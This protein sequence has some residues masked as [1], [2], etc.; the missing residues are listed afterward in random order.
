MVGDRDICRGADM[1]CSWG[2]RRLPVGETK[3][4]EF[5]KII[6]VMLFLMAGVIVGFAYICSWTG[7]C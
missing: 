4:M 2:G 6:A 5:I 7:N 1:D 3:S